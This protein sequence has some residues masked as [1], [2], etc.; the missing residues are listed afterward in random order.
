M[1][2][3][4]SLNSLKY[5]SDEYTFCGNIYANEIISHILKNLHIYPQF[6]NPSCTLPHDF[7]NL[8]NLHEFC[9]AYW[10]DRIKIHKKELV[11]RI[12]KFNKHT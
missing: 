11:R 7:P 1:K 2:N 10:Q 5:I 4:K 3:K 9:Q 12:N 6:P 8:T